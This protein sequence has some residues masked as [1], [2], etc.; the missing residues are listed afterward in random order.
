[1]TS[2]KTERLASKNSLIIRHS[3][4]ITDNSF[5][6]IQITKLSRQ[7]Q[8]QKNKQKLKLVT[9]PLINQHAK[10]IYAFGS[11]SRST[12]ENLATCSVQPTPNKRLAHKNS[13]S[14]KALPVLENNA[15]NS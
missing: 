5:H 15:P 8:K 6:A 9:P 1:L 14:Q 11:S 12:L 10:L 13:A 7:L 3:A 4:E 2:I